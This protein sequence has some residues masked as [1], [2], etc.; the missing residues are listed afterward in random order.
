MF[1]YASTTMFL[2][3]YYFFNDF[4]YSST[5]CPSPLLSQTYSRVDWLVGLEELSNFRAP[6]FPEVRSALAANRDLIDEPSP[7]SVLSPFIA[8]RRLL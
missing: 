5:A 1:L 8:P 2:F 4:Y 3:T 6:A 7:V